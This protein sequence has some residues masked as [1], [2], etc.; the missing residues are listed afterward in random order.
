MKGFVKTFVARIWPF[1]I[2]RTNNLPIWFGNYIVI[3]IKKY[4]VYTNNSLVG[5]GIVTILWL[6]KY[7]TNKLY[8]QHI[9][10]Y[11]DIHIDGLNAI[12]YSCLPSTVV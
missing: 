4:T 6:P 3:L 1:F 11:D 2:G 5:A 9:Q 8:M 7:S 12:T 10:I